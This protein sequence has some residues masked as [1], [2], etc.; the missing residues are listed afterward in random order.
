MNILFGMPVIWE[1]GGYEGE[2]LLGGGPGPIQIAGRGD[3]S[4]HR[5]GAP[6]I[7]APSRL[8]RRGKTSS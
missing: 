7:H 2:V 5:D 8:P 1:T 3:G 6:G 4:G